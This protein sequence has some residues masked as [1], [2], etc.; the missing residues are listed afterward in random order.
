MLRLSA[1]ASRT[2]IDLQIVNG[3]GSGT[4]AVTHSTQLMQFAEA[5]ATRDPDAIARTRE[6][7]L[8]VAGNDVVVDAAAVAGN[9]QRMV[10]I[11]DST[12]IPVDARMN[13]LSGSIQQDLDLRRFGS[14][15]NTPLPSA[16]QRVINVPKGAMMRGM[17]KLLGRR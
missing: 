5:V 16:V 9:F 8:A 14:A 11:A 12:G 15:T 6:A 10:R 7:L 2:D 1:D 4:S 3:D 13:A 17:I